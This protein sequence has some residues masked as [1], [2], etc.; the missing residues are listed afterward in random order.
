MF[1]ESAE[2]LAAPDLA[3]GELQYARLALAGLAQRHVADALVRA[4]LVVVAQEL[5]D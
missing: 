4:F 1:E 2:P 3:C 5:I